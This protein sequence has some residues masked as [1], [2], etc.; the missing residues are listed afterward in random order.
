MPKGYHH[1]TYDK[2]CQIQTLK[3]RGDSLEKIAE[4]LKV[5]RSSIYREITRNS[6]DSN[7]EYH[8]AN[9][10]AIDRRHAASSQKTKMT[11]G[12]ISTIQEKLKLQWSPEQISG[13]LKR[14]YGSKSVSHEVIYSYVWENKQRG[15]NLYKNLRHN[16]KKYNKRGSKNAG[17]GFIPN[18]VDIDK[19][20]SIVEEKSRIGDWEID[21]II[22]KNHKG[23]IVSMVDR[24]SKLTMLAKV[25]RK[26][27]HDVGKALISK[28]SQVQG[29]VYTITSDNGK[30]FANH[31]A[32]SKELKTDFYF[33]H[34]YHSWERGLNEHTN[35]LVRQYIPKSSHFDKVSTEAIQQV[36]DLLNNRPRKILQFFTPAEVFNSRKTQPLF[37]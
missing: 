2:R 1:L 34:P 19:R 5:H 24:H 11:S 22:G 20:P 6:K 13:R 17:R 26:T 37:K 21:T 29:S 10:K 12:L 33:A 23:A 18:R 25:S 32:I 8:E 3:E 28:L 16:G 14:L 4:T 30:E 36:E 15:G 7:Y 31:I 35:G 9:K 27:A